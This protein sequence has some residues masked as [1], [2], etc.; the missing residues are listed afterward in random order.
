MPP[1]E[2]PAVI[3]STGMG[4][5]LHTPH[6][7]TRDTHTPHC[8]P[9]QIHTPTLCFFH[10]TPHSV[11]LS[12]S[13][14]WTRNKEGEYGD[15]HKIR[16]HKEIRHSMSPPSQFQGIF[17]AGLYRTLWKNE[18]HETHDQCVV[19]NGW[20]EWQWLFS[21]FKQKTGYFVG[22][23]YI[24]KSCFCNDVCVCHFQRE[25]GSVL[26]GNILP[27]PLLKMM[28]FS[29]HLNHWEREREG[30]TQMLIQF[31]DFYWGGKSGSLIYWRQRPV[32]THTHTLS[33]FL[34]MFHSQ[35]YSFGGCHPPPDDSGFA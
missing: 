16:I 20:Q 5:E 34:S 7:P 21:V 11:L 26:F 13:I 14:L 28:K 6:T 32:W 17:F 4:G 10:W 15:T 29:S 23:C 31:T 25:R 24:D 8:P 30:N 22:E 12:L 3:A 18:L 19:G 2:H 9:Y 1:H 35:E 27:L 33:L